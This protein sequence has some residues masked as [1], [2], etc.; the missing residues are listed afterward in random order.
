M[1]ILSKKWIICTSVDHWECTFGEKISPDPLECWV[2]GKCAFPVYINYYSVSSQFSFGAVC[3]HNQVSC[4]SGSLKAGLRG[5]FP[6][7][8]PG[9]SNTTKPSWLCG[10][11]CTSI[12]RAWCPGTTA[13]ST[14]R[15][16]GPWLLPRYV[17]RTTQAAW[18]RRQAA[19]CSACF[20]QAELLAVQPVLS[21]LIER[22]SSA[23]PR[24]SGP[25]HIE[26]EE[27]AYGWLWY[28]QKYWL[29]LPDKAEVPV[30]KTHGPLV[31]WILLS[32]DV[33][34]S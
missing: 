12:W 26:W 13:W 27:F 1:Y 11:S 31:S 23:C 10:T 33:M 16:S 18:R 4:L 15:K 30:E 7:C 24:G 29:K 19:P 14:S 6:L 32:F 2:F 34:E 3:K 5:V 21:Y 17:L 25:S 8:L 28:K 20:C 22:V 9:S